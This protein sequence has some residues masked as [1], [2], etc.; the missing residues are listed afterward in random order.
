MASAGTSE[1]RTATTVTVGVHDGGSLAGND[2]SEVSSTASQGE[3]RDGSVGVWIISLRCEVS[4]Q[5]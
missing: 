4:G 2:S 5:R 1:G 3:G